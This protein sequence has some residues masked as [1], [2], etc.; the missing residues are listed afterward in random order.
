MQKS[1]ISWLKFGDKNSKFVHTST[2]IRRRQ[3]KIE[4]LKDSTGQ[5]ISDQDQLKRLAVQYYSNLL[6]SNPEAG[7]SFIKGRSPRLGLEAKKLLSKTFRAE[8]VQAAMK[9]MSPYKA[10]DPDGF[11]I[12]FYQRS[13]NIIG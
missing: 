3:N 11:Q 9:G 13:W 5:C 4:S 10:P 6:K 2:L 1:R 7:G 12:I 8:E